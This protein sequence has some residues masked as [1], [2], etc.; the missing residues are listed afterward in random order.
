MRE[1]ASPSTHTHTQT[2]SQAHTHSL[3]HTTYSS[4]AGGKASISMAVGDRLIINTPGAGGCGAP[5]AAQGTGAVFFSW[6]VLET[7]GCHT[8]LSFHRKTGREKREERWTVLLWC[9]LV[10]RCLHSHQ[11]PTAPLPLALTHRSLNNARARWNVQC[12]W[13]QRAGWKER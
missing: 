6:L 1:C 13:Q 5:L 12:W 10:R 2:H 11:A 4:V 3:A 7:L 9:F 8:E